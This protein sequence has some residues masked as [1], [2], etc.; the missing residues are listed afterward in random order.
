MRYT[1]PIFPGF[2]TQP[3]CIEPRSA[4]QKLAEE[5]TLLAS[6]GQVV[7]LVDMQLSAC[8]NQSFSTACCLLH[9]QSARLSPDICRAIR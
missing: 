9:N 2:H 8:L 5:M 6:L 4:Q 7:E 1:P 3:L